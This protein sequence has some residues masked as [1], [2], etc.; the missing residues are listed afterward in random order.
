[1]QPRTCIRWNMRRLS[2]IAGC[3]ALGHGARDVTSLTLRVRVRVRVYG[4]VRATGHHRARLAWIRR[5]ALAP[6]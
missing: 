3:N 2:P 6:S 5:P 4:V 1:M